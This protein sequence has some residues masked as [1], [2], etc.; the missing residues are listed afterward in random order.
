LK[1]LKQL[2]EL[3]DGA[4]IGDQ[5]IVITG[6]GSIFQGAPSG[7]ITFIEESKL[8]S[9]AEKTSASALIVPIDVRSSIKSILVVENPRLAFA[10]IAKIFSND[11]LSTGE[12][13]SKS[14]I[15]PSA[16]I[17]SNVSIH[18]FAV[19]S[20]N[21][22]IGDN[23]IIGPGS[24]LGMGTKLGN[25]CK[26]YTNVVIEENTVIGDD[27]IIHSSSTIGSDGFGF[28]KSDEDN[29]KIPQLGNVIIEDNVEIFAGVTIDKGTIGP[30]IIGNGSKLGDNVHVGHNAVIGNNCILVTHVAIGGSSKIGNNCTL[31]GKVGISDHIEIGNNVK[32]SAGSFA[33]KNI[34]DGSFCSG[35]PAISHKKD[36][37]IRASSRKLPELIK[38]VSDLEMKINKLE[39]K[40]QGL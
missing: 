22:I 32:I 4:I 3:V 1:T 39:N 24:F 12:I 7:C 25:R 40:L 29:I 38:K 33:L 19:I 27:V 20:E 21:T 13:S 14:H 17:G 15:H 5:N 8:L 28:T 34:K 9:V 36:Y 2:A 23:C 18:P 26:I 16:L 6:L 37:R 10:L 31:A 30:T 35:H 11:T